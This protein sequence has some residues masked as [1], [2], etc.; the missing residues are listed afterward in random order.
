MAANPFLKPTASYTRQIDPVGQYIE[1]MAQYLATMTGDPVKDCRAKT[2]QLLMSEHTGTVDPMVRHYAR[3][4]NGD[5]VVQETL[6]SQYIRHT[7]KNGD[8]LAP[9][10]T[11]Y[12]HP[13][14]KQSILVNFVEKNKK[15]RSIA[16]KKSHQS[17]AEGNLAE[18][19]YQE[20]VQNKK[21]IY[22]NAMS[23]A[24]G[25]EGT[26]LNNPTAH[27]TL[28][29]I[30]RTVVSLCNATNERMLAGNRHYWSPDIVLNNLI[31]TTTY[32]DY[33]ALSDVMTRYEL[34]YPSVEQ[35]L[36]VIHY[37][38]DLYWHDTLYFEPIAAYVHRL[39]PLQRAAF[40]YTGDFYHLRVFN[41][42]VVRT[43]L[44]ALSTRCESDATDLLERITQLNEDVVL[45]THQLCSDLIRG[46]GKN[47]AKMHE[48][49]V[50]STVVGTAEHVLTVVAAYKDL[51]DVLFLSSNI[52]ASI[53]QI[54]HMLRR[55]V[56]LSDTDSSCF[57]VDKWVEWYRG[58]R[59]INGD[60]LAIGAAVAYLTTQTMAHI[61][62]ILSANINT[63][64]KYRHTLAVKGE[65]IWDA[66]LFTSKA[67]HYAARTIYQEGNV[68]ATAEY[69]KKGVHL[70]SSASP[71]NLIER[72]HRMLYGI[73]D[74]AASGG[75]LSIRT[76]LKE[77]ADIERSITTSLLNGEEEF[78][79]TMMIKDAGGYTLSA[80]KSPYQFY[81]LWN[82]VFGPK[83]G[84]VAPPPYTS[85][86][87]PTRLSN[88]TD[89]KHWLA[90]ME[91]RALSARIAHW[92]QSNNK[93][94]IGVF[95]LPL[96]YVQSHGLPSEIKTVLDTKRVVLEL[97]NGY[98]LLLE[99]IGFFCKEGWTLGEMGY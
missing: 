1:Q 75:T 10:F 36:A 2:L 53:A 29:S 31:S 19:T 11:T 47:Y 79:R 67:K 81:V 72:L 8:I 30:T 77:I 98:R 59:I 40:V 94:C 74:V 82:E 41:P 84:T 85:I 14:V 92:M 35:T 48:A 26:V 69:E 56:P 34:V 6:L 33:A 12:L 46:M 39:T 99:S 52:P 37:S 93:Q 45:L 89:I 61:L 25:T 9:S 66:F 24:F 55:V 91:D 96:E 64:E 21:K 49:G 28:T 90:Q 20:N 5:S 71:I 57:T 50:L 83:Y 7:V 58:D 70:I 43:L 68:F 38:T 87:I 27:S 97:T 80:N 13:S 60:S 32:T 15:L 18:H 78:Y 3:G 63:P 23:G 76:V 54:P 44:T 88:K 17:K 51:I 73:L 95:L 65:F 42:A 86:K 22:N 62:A 16:K 4:D